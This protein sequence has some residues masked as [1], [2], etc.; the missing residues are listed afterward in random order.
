MSQRKNRYSMLGREMFFLIVMVVLMIALMGRVAYIKI[1]HGSDYQAAAEAQQLDSTDVTIPALRGP[2][3]DKNG[4]ILAESTRIYNVILDCQVL[5][6]SS[7]AK[8]K[9]TVEQLVSALGLGSE[10]QVRRYMTSEYADYRYLKF[11]PGKGISTEKMQII[12]AGIN[13]GSVVGV[14]FE[15]AESRIYYNG[16]LAAHVLGFNGVYGVEQYYDEYLQGTSGRKMVVAGSGVSY[17]EEYIEAQDGCTLTL[18]IDSKV[19]GI[20]EQFMATGVEVTNA[21]QGAAILMK[22]ST[23]EIT[24][25]CEVPT[26]DLNDVTTLIGTSEKWLENNP[27]KSDPDYYAN[28][29]NSFL[30]SST[31]E[32]GSCFKPMFM[33]AALNEGIVT[34]NSP[35]VCNGYYT[36]YDAEVGCAGGEWHGLEIPSDIIANSCNVGMTQIS[37]LFPR[38]DWLLYQEAYGLGNLTGIDIAGEAGDNR[39]LIYV[40]AEEAERLGT[41]N[42]IGFFEKAT[43]AF[44]QG[45]RMTPMQLICAMN[46]VIN[47]GEYLRPYV[48]SQITDANGNVIASQTKEVLRYTIDSWIS[49]E[50]R[51]YMRRV[52]REG[53]GMNALVPGYDIGGKTGT[54]EKT[55]ENG[56]YAEGKYVVS[57]ISFTPVEDP[58]Y[59]L[60][61]ILDE[62]DK[63]VSSQSAHLAGMI[64]EA[65]L[66]ELGLYPDPTLNQEAVSPSLYD[67]TISTYQGISPFDLEAERAQAGEGASDSE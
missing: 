12:Q 16:S 54:A 35:F 60:L 23:G 2:I 33:A 66:P 14:W 7:E 26:Y 45:F 63:N 56:G 25:M 61:V 62:T 47:G 36:V 29:W 21:V 1:V 64:W 22:C 32:P 28:V 15:E 3:L 42:A 38:A 9:S 18:T 13:E 17:V 59:V 34:I 5:I 19:Q 31:F 10:D 37:L 39:S 8:Q 53:T 4:N 24:A 50:L 52:V 48:V 30:I 6:E 27:D 51:T 58:E 49:H 46:S 67:L 11:D 43:T 65:I 20:I 44:G 57:F 55:D 41:G 40:S